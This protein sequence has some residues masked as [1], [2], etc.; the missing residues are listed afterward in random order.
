MNQRRTKRAVGLVLLIS[1][2]SATE[3][4]IAPSPRPRRSTA[5]LLEERDEENKKLE[6]SPVNKDDLGDWSSAAS[7]SFG[8]LLL[9]MQKKEE[10]L[11]ASRLEADVVDLDQHSSSS[12]SSS[13]A[14]EGESS[15]KSSSTA[16]L[17]SLPSMDLET[18]RE[19]D[20]SVRPLSLQEIADQKVKVLELSPLYKAILG[21]TKTGLS[22]STVPVLSQ[23][24]HYVKRIGRDMRM[25]ALN[26]VA[27]TETVEQWKVFAQENGG[28]YPILDTIRIGAQ[29]IQQEGN[30][31]STPWM[32]LSAESEADQQEQ[33]FRAACSA[34]RALRDLCALSPELAAVVTDGILRA[35]AAW[36]GGLM[37]DFYTMLQYASE[38]PKPEAANFRDRRRNH[39]DVRLR[40]KLYVCQVL[41]ALAVASDEAIDAIR[42][43]EGLKDA[44]LT[45]S[46]YDRKERTRRWLRYPGEIAKWLWRRRR[47]RDPNALRRPF[48][49]AANLTNDLNGSVQRTANQILAAIGFNQWIPK[50]PGQRGLRILSLDGGGS[51][52]MV[53][54]TALQR[55]LKTIGNGAEVADSFDIVAGTSTG[56]IIAFLTALRRETSDQAVERYNELIKQIFVKSAL[57]TPMMLFTTATYDET[58]FMTILSKILGNYIMLDSR[59]DPAVPLVFCVTSKMSSTPTHVSLLRNY[60]YARGELPDTFTIDPDKAREELG[61]GLDLE[62]PLLRSSNYERKKGPEGGTPGMQVSS[63]ASRHPGSFRVLQR[64]ALRA[65]TAAPTVFRPVMMGGEIYADGG[66]VSSNPTAVA[67]HE[68]RVIYPDIPIELVVSIGT[69]AFMEQKSAP[70]IG[71]DGII[72]QIVGAA[73]DGEQTHHIL[74][75]ILGDPGSMVG[76]SSGGTRYFRFNPV[77]GKPDEFPIDVTDPEKLLTLQRIATEYMDEPEQKERIDEIAAILRGQRWTKGVKK[78][79]RKT[80]AETL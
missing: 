44:V 67:I 79:L 57:S 43:T 51:R 47:L 20:E 17:E 37:V 60:N 30:I 10:A 34:C 45:C 21:G 14:A 8:N 63:D 11:S 72:G 27:S 58:N 24:D 39:R 25:L 13:T 29:S 62:H 52:G 23:P 46:S 2:P 36:R 54:V 15:S 80:K 28:L 64:F 55:M 35:N 38:D 70:R 66:I 32:G 65:S 75:D 76:S 48:L 33:T 56:G 41:L 12:S 7:D 78:I 59:A 9:Q 74:E 16:P 26:I 69:G 1:S 19:L 77:I 4:W 61:L 6:P 31:D 68:A 3:A 50:I 53:A 42:S 73:T 18:A 49:E 71:W 5:L 22:S 40:C